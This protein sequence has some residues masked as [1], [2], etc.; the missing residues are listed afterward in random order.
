MELRD[1]APVLGRGFAHHIENLDEL[2]L[3]KVVLLLHPLK[4]R[5]RRLSQEL[6]EDT[7]DGP[8]VDGLGVV[9]SAEEQLG[10][11][12]PYRYYHTV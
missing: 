4:E 7:S 11:A 2:V 5:A 9:L 10:R 1:L 8:H 6:A 3:L 12:V